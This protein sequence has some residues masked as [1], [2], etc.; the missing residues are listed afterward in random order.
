MTKLN[1]EPK[2]S[3]SFKKNL[4]E[5]NC[6]ATSFISAYQFEAHNLEIILEQERNRQKQ[7][8]DAKRLK[9]QLNRSCL[10]SQIGKLE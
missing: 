3:L 9:R 1:K 5:I 4:A 6:M 2:F 8:L 10:R 7:A